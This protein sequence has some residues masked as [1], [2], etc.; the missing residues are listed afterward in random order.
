MERVKKAQLRAMG[1]P[2]GEEAEEAAAAKVPD[3]YL[4]V[5][6]TDGNLD[7][8]IKVLHR[9]IKARR[10]ESAEDAE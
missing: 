3:L 10:P 4:T 9:M 6:V 1:E 8:M 7:G 5:P 2:E